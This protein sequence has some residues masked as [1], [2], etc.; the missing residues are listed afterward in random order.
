MSNALSI[1]WLRGISGR[2]PTTTRGSTNKSILHQYAAQK[3]RLVF[4][5]SYWKTCRLIHRS[6][7]LVRLTK[8][9]ERKRL[10]KIARRYEEHMHQVQNQL[11]IE[12]SKSKLAPLLAYLLV[13]ASV[14]LFSVF[15]SLGRVPTY[16][17]LLRK[18]TGI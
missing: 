10:W 4:L 8:W 5:H 9:A 1:L 11:L 2:E 18:R 13:Y 15:G 6:H 16:P 3:R 14:A 7:E 17:R 12:R